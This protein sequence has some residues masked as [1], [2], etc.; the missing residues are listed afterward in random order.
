MVKQFIKL[1][2]SFIC[3]NCNHSVPLH[4]TSSRDHCNNCIY[5]LHV[6]I[7]P[8]DRSNECKGE[9]IPIGMKFMNAKEKIVYR[10]KKCSKIVNCITAPDDSREEIENLSK[11]VWH[12]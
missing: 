9:L 5:G 2:E 3:Y 10:C 7:N 12:E 4:E 1:N 11:K 8:G 6:D